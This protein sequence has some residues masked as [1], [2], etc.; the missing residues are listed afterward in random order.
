MN[1][2]SG[3]R[4]PFML[5]SWAF[6]RS[7]EAAAGQHLLCWF[8]LFGR[9]PVVSHFRCYGSKAV[10]QAQPLITAVWAL[11]AWCSVF[12]SCLP[13][14]WLPG[15]T[16]VAHPNS[17]DATVWLHFDCAQVHV[18]LVIVKVGCLADMA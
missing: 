15:W 1:T 17:L 16:H 5:A 6:P 2:G 8:L 11:G 10:V 4:L 13:D 18:C 3:T 7:L 12:D 14:M 9:V